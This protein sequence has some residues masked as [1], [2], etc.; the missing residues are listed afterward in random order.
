MEVRVD[1]AKII[2]SEDADQQVIVLKERDGER[3]FPIVIGMGEAFAIDRRIKGIQT[4][5]PLTHELLASVIEQMGGE[6]EK[7]VIHDLR[8]HTFY[9]KLI[10]RQNGRVIEVD[11]RPSDAVAV[12]V[13]S[14]TQLY[15]AE[16]V[17][18]E[19]S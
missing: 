5:R 7:V 15:V 6:L 9:A 1:L 3:A 14:D 13:G 8:E 16:H 10:I 17:I 11:S 18:R 2:I 4:P 12:A 19:I